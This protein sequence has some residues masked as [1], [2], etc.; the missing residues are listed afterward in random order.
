MVGNFNAASLSN[1]AQQGFTPLWLIYLCLWPSWQQKKKLLCSSIRVYEVFSFFKTFL[2]ILSTT[3]LWLCHLCCSSS[4]LETLFSY[5]VVWFYS[6]S[7]LLSNVQSDVQFK[8]Q[9]FKE[10]PLSA[11]APRILQ[12]PTTQRQREMPPA[13]AHSDTKN[14]FCC[15]PSPSATPSLLFTGRANETI[16]SPE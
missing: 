3:D 16:L 5:F 11:L 7:P 9:T 10:K 2:L 1:M 14:V 12:Y 4:L 13:G 8:R 6:P 15:L